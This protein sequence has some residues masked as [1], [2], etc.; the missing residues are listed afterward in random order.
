MVSG[1]FILQNGRTE[2][3]KE[4]NFLLCSLRNAP[5]SKL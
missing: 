4:I 5:D 2:V 1:G 3:V